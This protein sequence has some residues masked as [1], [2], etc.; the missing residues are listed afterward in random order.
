MNPKVA[1]ILAALAPALEG[2]LTEVATVAG[3]PAAGAAVSA[4][5][6]IGN[7]ALGVGSPAA[8]VAIAAPAVGTVPAAEV[9]PVK[10]AKD[11]HPVMASTGLS[12]LSP[13]PT[14]AGAIPDTS[15]QSLPDL[16]ARFAALEQKVNALIAATG[17]NGSAAMA[18]HP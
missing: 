18:A 1:A 17:M 6:T 12:P 3:G 15:A 11:A 2:A 14:T 4:V 8:A 10:P 16:Y 5:E 9:Q 13:T 7:A